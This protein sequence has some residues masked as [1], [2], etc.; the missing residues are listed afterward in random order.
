MDKDCFYERLNQVNLGE[1]GFD[2]TAR[3]FERLGRGVGDSYDATNVL[4]D[5]SEGYEFISEENVIREQF[6]DSSRRAK[7]YRRVLA[8]SRESREEDYNER[9]AA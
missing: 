2:S 1:L 9:C 5:P 3:A 4:G 6:L 8:D 7:E